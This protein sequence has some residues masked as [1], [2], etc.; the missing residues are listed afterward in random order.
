LTKKIVLK[1]SFKDRDRCSAFNLKWKR[2]PEVTC[3]HWE[4]A[5]KPIN[6][7]LCVG[8]SSRSIIHLVCPPKLCISFIFVFEMVPSGCKIFLGGKQ[9]VLW[10]INVQMANR[11]HLHTE[12]YDTAFQWIYLSM[13]I[14]NLAI[15]LF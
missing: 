1:L 11:A 8:Y 15:K 9:G 2:V 5:L 13:Y 10:E 12:I 6:L 4:K 3:A 7:S 14:I